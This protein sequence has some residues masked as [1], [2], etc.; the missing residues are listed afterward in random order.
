MRER[1]T[2][3]MRNVYNN[4]NVQIYTRKKRVSVRKQKLAEKQQQTAAIATT[5]DN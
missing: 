5:N 3:N 2:I 1:Q 4:N